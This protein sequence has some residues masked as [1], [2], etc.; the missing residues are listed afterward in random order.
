MEHAVLSINHTVVDISHFP[1]WKRFMLIRDGEK[2]ISNAR[3][4]LV[5]LSQDVVPERVLWK[6]INHR[7]IIR[8]WY[9]S[10][11]MARVH[12]T[13]V[14]KSVLRCIGV[15][16]SRMQGVLPLLQ[17]DRRKFDKLS[18][19]KKF[20]GKFESS[21]KIF[22]LEHLQWFRESLLLIFVVSFSKRLYL[23]IFMQLILN[24]Q[25]KNKIPKMMA[26]LNFL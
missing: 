2:K 5:N 16:I 25:E 14:Q 21:F 20:A 18:L 26:V 8:Q 1:H 3:T 19:D 13:R 10:L 12:P 15:I 7:C 6:F 17:I 11:R 23:E 22:I 9:I 24:Q 4:P